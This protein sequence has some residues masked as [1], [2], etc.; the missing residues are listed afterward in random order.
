MHSAYTNIL[1]PKQEVL[2]RSMNSCLLWPHGWYQNLA[3]PFS[4]HRPPVTIM[5]FWG[6]AVG[7]ERCSSWLMPEPG[8]LSA[9]T[10]QCTRSVECMV[11]ISTPLPLPVL[12]LASPDAE[13]KCCSRC[14]ASPCWSEATTAVTLPGGNDEQRKA[15]YLASGNK[16]P[17]AHATQQEAAFIRFCCHVRTLLIANAKPAVHHLVCASRIERQPVAGNSLTHSP[18]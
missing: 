3:L 6:P 18:T 10:G 16:M 17:L 13:L 7:G 4:M 5:T 9:A 14:V 15:R 2:Q 12:A 1:Q 11:G 8:E